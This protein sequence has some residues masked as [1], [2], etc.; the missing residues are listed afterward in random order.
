ML[1]YRY[2]KG[3]AENTM[4]KIKKIIVKYGSPFAAFAF[5]F[6]VTALGNYCHYFFHEPE[7][8]KELMKYKKNE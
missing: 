1:I 5:I 8:P 7:V 4:E 3:K 2:S 6:N